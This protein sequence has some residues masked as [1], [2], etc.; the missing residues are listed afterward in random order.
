[1]SPHGAPVGPAP[2]QRTR[3][4]VIPSTKL[5]FK[6]KFPPSHIFTSHQ[7]NMVW[8]EEVVEY[9]SAHTTNQEL[10]ALI[11]KVAHAKLSE[12]GLRPQEGVIMRAYAYPEKYVS[13]EMFMTFSFEIKGTTGAIPMGLIQRAFELL[14]DNGMLYKQGTISE[15]NN[16]MQ[17]E[18][19][20]TVND[21]LVKY[22]AEC[23]L[24]YNHLF[25]FEY[26]INRYNKSVVKIEV[27]HGET[28]SIG[29]GWFYDLLVKDYSSGAKRLIVTNNHVLEGAS[30]FKVLYKDDTVLTSYE[31]EML[32]TESGVDIALIEVE[33]DKSLPDFYLN[34]K[35]PLLEDVITIGYPAVP[36]AREAYQL[37]HRGEVNAQVT[38]YFGQE[39]LIISARTAP[40]NSGSPVI[41]DTGR[42]VGMVTSELFEKEA[43][44]EK[45]ITPYSACIPASTI[46]TSV[47][48]S[49][50]YKNWLA[51]Q[52]V[53]S[54]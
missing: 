14:A 41:D 43:F 33:L 37:V 38:D 35:V 52:G 18:Q 25:G 1:M 3:L 27:K 4:G 44:K 30:S 20:Y 34:T 51:E 50:I 17:V 42:V 46:H 40:G 49:R 29:T 48:N 28:T 31:S 5:F 12:K 32:L 26:I 22:L 7:P 23:K 13:W 21:D 11:K 9:V 8:L 10:F 24:V 39:L 36:L 53:S 45:G 2:G 16:L 54:D 15:H 6:M 19:E 47:I